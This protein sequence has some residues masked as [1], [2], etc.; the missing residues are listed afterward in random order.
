M[1]AAYPTWAALRSYLT[2]AE[3]GNLTC[4]YQDIHY[5]LIHYTKGKSN[6]NLPHVR[7]FRSVVW[8][9]EK[10]VPVSVTPPKSEQGESLPSCALGNGYVMPFYDGVMVGQFYCTYTMRSIIHTRTYFGGGNTFYGKKTFGE[11]CS[12]A[13][14]IQTLGSA[15]TSYTYILQH[16]EN[17]IVTPVVAPRLVWVHTA[18]FLESGI[19]E[20]RMNMSRAVPY[21]PTDTASSAIILSQY[22]ASMAP[23]ALDQGIIIYDATT[24]QRYKIRTPAYTAIRKMRGNSSSLNYIW[25]SAWQSHYWL[26][27]L[28]AFPEERSAAMALAER[29][30]TVTS[31]VY[32]NYKNIFKARTHTMQQAPLKYKSL[33]YT[34]HELYKTML[35]PIGQS[36]TWEE[37]KRFMNTRDIPQMLYVLNWEIRATA[38]AT[39]A[40]TVATVATDEEDYSDMP[41]LISIADLLPPPSVAPVIRVDSG[42][43]H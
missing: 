19:V 33:L 4:A 12:E 41:G 31:E 16:P 21:A 18:T 14:G 30:K 17:R 43:V 35:Q 7:L 34:L 26:N 6:L 37:C 20:S 13:V 11:M 42:P 23:G 32:T 2:S 24:G 28:T 27:Y 22:K 8:D 1:K 40:A 36:V 38:A 29:W 9:I 5:A 3:G 25:L 10:N 39:V 15:G